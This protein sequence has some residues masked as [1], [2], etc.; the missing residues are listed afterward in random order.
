LRAAVISH[1]SGLAGTPL[2]GQVRSAATNASESASSDAAMSR[3]LEA[4]TAS[5]RP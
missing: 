4:N 2:S 5:N 1:A 3:D